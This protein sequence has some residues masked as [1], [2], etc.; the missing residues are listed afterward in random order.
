MLAAAKYIG[1]GLL[2]NKYI[3]EMKSI[4][5]YSS[6]YATAFII[7]FLYTHLFDLYLIEN[8]YLLLTFSGGWIVS[9][10]S[11]KPKL[12]RFTK[13]EQKQYIIPENWRIYDSS[14]PIF[15]GS[16]ILT[17]IGGLEAVQLLAQALK[18]NFNL[19]CYI[20]KHG[21][22]YVIRISSKSLPVLQDLLSL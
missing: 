7:Y 18:D 15:D 13:E 1:A 2:L 6:I 22:G 3:K 12:K 21:N 17:K 4:T 11:D 10:Q 8:N 20:N 19:I 5:L 16:K 14:P 9:S